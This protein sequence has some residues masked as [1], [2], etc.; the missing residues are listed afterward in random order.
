MTRFRALSILGPLVLLAGPAR[1]QDWPM[2]LHDNFRSGVTDARLELPLKEAWSFQ[3]LRPPAPAWPEPARQDFFHDYYDLRAVETYDYA[4]HVVAAGDT[5][6]FGSSS[7]DKIYALDAENGTIRWTFPV[8]GPVRFAPVW[9]EGRLYAGSDDGCVYCLSAGDGALVWKCRVAPQERMIP[10]NGRMISLWPVR[11]GLVVDGG[12]VYCSAG[13]FP[14]QGT[15]LAALDARTGAVQYR[16]RLEV[17]PQGYMLASPQRLYVPTGRTSPAIFS[18]ADGTAEGQLPSAGGAYAVLADDVMVTGPGRGPKELLASDVQTKDTIAT[19]GG[20][21]MLVRGSR[22]YL[23]SESEV[24]AFDRGRYLVLSRER[25]RLQRQRDALQKSLNKMPKGQPEARETQQQIEELAAQMGRLD[26]Q[27]KACYLWTLDGRHPHSM[28]LAGGTLFVGGENEISARRAKSPGWA[29]WTEGLSGW[30]S[31]AHRCTSART[32]VGFSVGARPCRE[33][34]NA[35]RRRFV[36]ILIPATSTQGGMKR[37]PTIWLVRV[38]R[39]RVTVLCSTAA[40][41]AWR[42]SWPGGHNSRLSVW[43]RMRTGR[44]VPAGSSTRPVSPAR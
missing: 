27:M 24:A 9:A 19:F 25:V 21:R 13:L 36:P 32:R 1:C 26:A 6:Y 2:Y 15:Y 29:P 41:A 14:E 12:I 42:A 11:T 5:V 33:S 20:V 37:R 4:F 22:A 34:R 16:R 39:A 31:P 44:T 8:E 40:T 30:R 38:R 3:P 10:G 35:S 23:Q 43:S 7:Q 18:R 17:L 28:V